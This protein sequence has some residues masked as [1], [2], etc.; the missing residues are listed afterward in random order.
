MYIKAH[1]K[2][3]RI[4]AAAAQVAYFGFFMLAVCLGANYPWAYDIGPDGTVV[5]GR[6]FALPDM[7][8]WTPE[9]GIELVR[10]GADGMCVDALGNLSVAAQTGLQ[11]RNRCTASGQK[12]AASVSGRGGFGIRP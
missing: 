11:N 5:N 10:T 2:S 12:S 3:G 9:R 6:N 1:Y 4:L 8:E 7:P